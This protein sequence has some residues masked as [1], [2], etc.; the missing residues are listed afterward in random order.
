MSQLAKIYISV[1]VC[2]Q[3]RP[4]TQAE[5][6]MVCILL[7][8]GLTNSQSLPFFKKVI[9]VVGIKKTLWLIAGLICL[10]LGLIGVVLPILP[11]TPFMLLATFFFAKSSK[12]LHNWLVT[13][14]QFGPS[15]KNW[16]EYGAISKP[17]KIAAI[18][19]MISVLLLGWFFGLKPIVLTIQALVM[20]G[21]AT[22]ILTR[23]SP[24]A[25][26]TDSELN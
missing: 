25:L 5:Q 19:T 2:D 4:P 3:N 17:A 7:H 1:V 21:S 10:G 23:P 18:L 22:F 16:H 12:R 14:P 15:I 24:P 9:I 20:M 13:H 8:S 26:K 6:C 11:T